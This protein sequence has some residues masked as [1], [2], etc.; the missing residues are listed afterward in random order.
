[1]PLRLFVLIPVLL[2]SACSVANAQIYRYVDE[3]GQVVYSSEKP[4]DIEKAEKVMIRNN[5]VSTPAISDDYETKDVVIYTATW[6]GV[7]KSAKSFF[8]KQGIA[9]NEYDIEKS[10]QG[11]RDYKRMRGRGVPIILVGEQRMNGFDP[12]RFQRLYSAE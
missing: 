6:C 3:N 12:A 5:S 2:A 10:A 7:C 1:M 8:E 4:A 11:K 9:Y